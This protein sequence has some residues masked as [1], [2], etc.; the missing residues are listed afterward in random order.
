MV[1]READVLGAAHRLRAEFCVAVEGVV[2]IRPEGNTNSEIPTGDVEVNVTALTVLGECA[3]LP[4]QLDE[5]AGEEADIG[6]ADRH[7]RPVHGEPFVPMLLDHLLEGRHHGMAP[8]ID[9]RLLIND[10]VA[11]AGSLAEVEVTEAFADDLVAR[12]V[13]P[14]G[15]PG[16]VPAEI[17]ELG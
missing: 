11:P 16:V 1:F 15:A 8:E 14:S 6:P 2:E 17:L 9:G 13:G 12:I 3:P 10:G 5:P 7:E 4:F